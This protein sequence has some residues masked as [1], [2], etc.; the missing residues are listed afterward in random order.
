MAVDEGSDW[1][2][3]KIEA[4]RANRMLVVHALIHSLRQAIATRNRR[5]SINQF[6]GDSVVP[7]WN[8][9]ESYVVW[10]VSSYTIAP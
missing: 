3:G 9:G 2:V 4:G 5:F 8:M 1:R 6:V 10:S 7:F